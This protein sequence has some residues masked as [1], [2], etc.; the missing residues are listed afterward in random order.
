MIKKF[1]HKIAPSKPA[2]RPTA[3]S[4][5][6]LFRSNK[7][8][9]KVEHPNLPFYPPSPAL[10]CPACQKIPENR[11]SQVGYPAIGYIKDLSP[12]ICYTGFTRADAMAIIGRAIS[13]RSEQ[14][15][16]V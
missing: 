11:Y 12:H 13:M 10:N 15:G 5:T 16:M 2:R 7:F 4:R 8:R 9:L 14:N 3:G 6:D 1:Y